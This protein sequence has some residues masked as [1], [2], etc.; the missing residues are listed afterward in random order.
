MSIVFINQLTHI[1]YPDVQNPVDYG[2]S[3]WDRSYLPAFFRSDVMTG[4][5]SRSHS[6][7]TILYIVY[8]SLCYGLG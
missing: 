8:F 1:P 7:Y 5:G 6:R 2:I 3:P 4:A